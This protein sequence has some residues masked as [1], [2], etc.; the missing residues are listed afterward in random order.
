MGEE[1]RMSMTDDVFYKLCA[2]NKFFL[3]LKTLFWV[4][5]AYFSS[6]IDMKIDDWA[7]F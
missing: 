4:R 1:L 5:L 6:L 3:L 2:R 7:C